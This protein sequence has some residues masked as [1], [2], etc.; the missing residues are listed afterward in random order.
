MTTATDATDTR[1][2]TRAIAAEIAAQLG[3]TEPEPLQ[4]LYRAVRNLGEERV[5]EFVAQALV[6]EENG[7]MLLPDGSRRRSL[8][9]V[10]FTLVRDDIGRKEFYRIFRPQGG[11]KDTATAPAA[12]SRGFLHIPP[13]RCS[14]SV[15][16]A[17]GVSESLR[18][19]EKGIV[20]RLM[21]PVKP[22]VA[23]GA[24]AEHRRPTARPPQDAP[25]DRD[26]PRA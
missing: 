14:K 7:G 20:R 23:A 26:R 2:A 12:G 10:F 22:A 9:G 21:R 11:P 1:Q 17:C 25:R 16:R 18:C 3:E 6:V 15:D 24:P 4:H 19:Y 8:G 5:R 13:K